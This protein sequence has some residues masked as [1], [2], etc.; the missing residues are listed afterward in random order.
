MSLAHIKPLLVS[1]QG[2]WGD[3]GGPVMEI[4]RGGQL[5]PLAPHPSAADRHRPAVL[6][7]PTSV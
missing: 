7:R 3:A 1:V 2:T 5:R 6:G 4:S